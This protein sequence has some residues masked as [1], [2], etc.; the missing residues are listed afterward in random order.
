MSDWVFAYRMG[1]GYGFDGLGG[2]SF[3]VRWGKEFVM[4][5]IEFLVGVAFLLVF[6]LL[7]WKV[8]GFFDRLFGLRSGLSFVYGVAII[9][10]VLVV[11]GIGRGVIAYMRGEE[12]F[13]N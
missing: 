11:R 1:G 12:S 5:V 8:I 6:G 13:L 10:V 4:G 2:G 9:P 7:A 3:M